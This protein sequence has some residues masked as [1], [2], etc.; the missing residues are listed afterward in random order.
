[1]P[2]NNG[3]AQWATHSLAEPRDEPPQKDKLPAHSQRDE[4]LSGGS[5]RI[6]DDHKRLAVTE[7]VG[8]V[9]CHHLGEA[10]H[11]VGHALDEAEESRRH[12]QNR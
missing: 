2:G 1:L 7:F 3:V 11:G 4:C 8:E 12:A 9:A 5:Q 10:R 6:A